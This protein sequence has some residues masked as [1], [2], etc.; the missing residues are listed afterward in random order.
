[1]NTIY[2]T[3]IGEELVRAMCEMYLLATGF[4]ND[5]NY[6]MWIAIHSLPFQSH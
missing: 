3:S 2:D 4:E 1:M 6:D 5:L